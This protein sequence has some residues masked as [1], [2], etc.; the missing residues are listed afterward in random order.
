MTLRSRSCIIDFDRFSGKAQ[1]RQDKSCDSSYY[2]YKFSSLM[3]HDED[4]L[5]IVMLVSASLLNNDD[6]E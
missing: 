6:D 5:W 3:I 2:L 4:I 1:V